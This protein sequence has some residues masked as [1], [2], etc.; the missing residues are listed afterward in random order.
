LNAARQ[1]TEADVCVVDV[2]VAVKETLEVLRH[3]Q[4]L[5]RC[6]IDVNVAEDVVVRANPVLIHQMVSNLV[7]NAGEATNGRGHVGIE[8]ALDE[9]GKISIHVDDDGDGIPAEQW[10]ELFSAL[11]T[12]KRDGTGLGL[13]SARACATAIGGHIEVGDSPRGGARFTVVIPAEARSAHTKRTEPAQ[14]AAVS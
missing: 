14:A 12:T 10:D 7:I 1:S 4:A 6:S 3:H 11:K 8:V 2:G 9:T 5:S 13:Y